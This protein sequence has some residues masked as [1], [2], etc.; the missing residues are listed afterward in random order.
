M[1]R[2]AML[3]PIFVSIVFGCAG[4]AAAPPVDPDQPFPGDW[5]DIAAAALTATMEVGAVIESSSVGPDTATFQIRDHQGRPGTLEATR[6]GDAIQASASIGRFGDP[7][8]E[9]RLLNELA[10]RLDQLH[11]VDYA[12]R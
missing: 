1:A 9:Q 8:A 6:E 10:R 7:E 3:A 11:G 5:D 12:P 2:F 4:R